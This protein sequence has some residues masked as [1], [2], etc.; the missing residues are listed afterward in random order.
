MKSPWLRWHQSYRYLVM[1]WFRYCLTREC[2]QLYYNK[3]R[4]Q[5]RLWRW[6]KARADQDLCDIADAFT[7]E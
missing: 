4:N 1:Y 6:A 5:R 3:R 2:F 7:F